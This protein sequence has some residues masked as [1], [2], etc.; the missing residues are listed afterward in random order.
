[1]IFQTADLARKPKWKRTMIKCAC[2]HFWAK[3]IPNLHSSQTV[4]Y[5]STSWHYMISTRYLPKIIFSIITLHGKE[6]TDL[7]YSITQ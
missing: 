5:F 1:M 2:I 4:R 6:G 7:W 3:H